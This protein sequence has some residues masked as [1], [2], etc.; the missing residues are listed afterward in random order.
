MSG[1]KFSSAGIP[2]QFLLPLSGPD[3]ERRVTL[4]PA[5]DHGFFLRLGNSI[6]T[7]T[8]RRIV[9]CME[10]L[11]RARPEWIVDCIPTYCTI[12]VLYDALR[13]ES[14]GVEGWIE[15]ALSGV[16][17]TPAE[18]RRVTI[19]VWYHASVGPDLESLAE[20]KGLTPEQVVEIHT[21]SEYLVYMLGFKPGF[22]F[23]GGLDE[24]LWAPR[25]ATPRLTVAAGS[26]GIGGKQTG[27]YSIT[28]P[29]GWRILGRTP[30]RLFD[31]ARENCFLLLPGDR[32]Q[33]TAVSEQQYRA[34]RAESGGSPQGP[35]SAGAE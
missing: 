14:Q 29:G 19:P 25:L 3:D 20:S 8:H 28:S 11:D 17:E 18:S 5:G 33:F 4:Y 21:G 31:P 12:L 23:M 32:V 6:S 1:P 22:P 9:S 26:V 24:R 15:K 2:R 7:E 16:V 30:L 34:L 35:R 27:I 10:A 13:V